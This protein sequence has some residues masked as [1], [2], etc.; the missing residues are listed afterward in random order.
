VLGGSP[1]FGEL[2][3]GLGVAA[4]DI[5]NG[6]LLAYTTERHKQMLV[7]GALALSTAVAFYFPWIEASDRI[8]VDA[9]L[10]S[11]LPLWLL[12]SFTNPLKNPAVVLSVAL[13]RAPRPQTFGDYMGRLFEA[14]GLAWRPP[15][16]ATVTP[17]DSSPHQR[18]T[19]RVPWPPQ[20]ARP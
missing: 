2:K 16:G 17:T 18:Q 11:Q 4:P 6:R 14:S 20:R 5:R 8:I 12:G 10:Q 9:A 1:T 13:P 3:L 15:A 19:P 7:A